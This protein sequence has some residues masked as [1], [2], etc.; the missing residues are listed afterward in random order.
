MQF[1]Q[2][3]I[4]TKGRNTYTGLTYNTGTTIVNN[5]GAGGGGT[6]YWT[7]ENN[8]RIYTEYDV[9]GKQD[10][11]AYG[12]GDVPEYFISV[13]DNLTSTSTT[14][15]LSANQGRVLKELIDNYSGGTASTVSWNNV[16]NKPTTI[17]GYGIT[18]AYTKSQVDNLLTSKSD[19]GHTHTFSSITNKPTTIAG[20]GITNAYT[21]SQVDNLLVGKS[22]TDHTHTF[23]S[24][25]DKPTTLSGYG[26]TDAVI[27]IMVFVCY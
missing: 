23:A 7:L 10:V 25:T 14:D 16:T 9:I 15:A 18:D 8:S 26:I 13:I 19:T 27:T 12:G 1:K 17:T 21:K 20:Y 24:I 2:I 11:S 4:P 22:D 6:N 5:G 3:F